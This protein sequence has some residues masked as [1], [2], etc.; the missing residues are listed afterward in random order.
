MFLANSTVNIGKNTSIT[1]VENQIHPS[2]YLNYSILNIESNVHIMFINNYR[3]GLMMKFSTIK[4]MKKTN[5][6]FISN[7][8]ESMEGVAINVE[9]SIN[10]NIEGDL[11][12][13]NNSGNRETVCIQTSTFSIRNNAI[14]E[15]INNSVKGQAGGMILYDTTVNIEDN[16]R[17]TFTNNTGSKIGAM[18]VLHSTL[19]VRNNAS[20][21]FMNNS[22]K[23]ESG[24]L[25]AVFSSIHF[26]DNTLCV[27]VQ[28]SAETAAGAMALWSSILHISN[29]TTMIFINNSAISV[30]GA[31]FIYSSRFILAN[32]AS[33]IIKFIGNSAKS[34]GAIVL[35]SSSLELIDGNSNIT[36][37]NN[38]AKE[39]GGAV[40]VRPDLLYYTVP[41]LYLVGTDC[42]YKT[43][44]TTDSGEHFVYF[45]NNSAEISGDDIYGASLALCRG[46]SVHIIQRYSN[47]L[48]SIS[49]DPLRV[50]VCDNEN[51]PLCQNLSYNHIKALPISSWNSRFQKLYCIFLMVYSDNSNA[52]K[53][54]A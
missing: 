21:T 30:G 38:S 23:K 8:N 33:M 51:K 14:L 34:G 46:S 16:A 47:P 25:E 22:V 48:S 42:L 20:I 10:M 24:A 52:K 31:I 19:Y 54:I 13:I 26:E 15:F 39:N 37:E 9:N 36:F 7:S 29:N 32:G 40:F 3:C 12:F 41:Y 18:A 50:C 53:I 4:I 5:I 2:I 28:N 43:N 27:F 35:L 6:T 49:G 11:F 17:L 1:F 44:S 45:I